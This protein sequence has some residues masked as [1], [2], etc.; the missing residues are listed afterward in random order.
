MDSVEIPENHLPSFS[1]EEYGS[2]ENIAQAVRRKLKLPSGPIQNLVGIIESLGIIIIPSKFGTDQLD[3]FTIIDESAT[4]IY[5]NEMMPGCRTRFTLAH[6]LGHI[7]M[8]HVP[9]PGIEE[10][11]NDF[12]SEFLMPSKDISKHFS[13]TKIDL[14]LLAMLKPVWKVAMQ[15]I[16][17]KA[18]KLGYINSNQ[19]RYLW[20]NLSKSG[21]KKREPAHLDIPKEKANLFSAIIRT[22]LSDLEYSKEELFEIIC[23]LEEN[24]NNIYWFM[25]DPK[26]KQKVISFAAYKSR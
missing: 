18:Y 13:G 10:E 8:G 25:S 26:P 7:L 16:L 3:G 14:H 23:T 12:A 11:A 4:I 22:H 2:P 19:H 6:E 1:I 24:F 20:M 5:I 17:I 21:Y 9:K 15:A